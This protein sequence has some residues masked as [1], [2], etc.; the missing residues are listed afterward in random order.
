M[1]YVEN[2]TRVQPVVD[3]EPRQSTPAT[4]WL[5]FLWVVARLS[6][7]HRGGRK[8]SPNCKCSDYL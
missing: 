5:H 8:C 1:A 6:W 4:S 3:V 7:Q 2:L